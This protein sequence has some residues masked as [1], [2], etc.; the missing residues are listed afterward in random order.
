MGKALRFAIYWL[1]SSLLLTL[2]D[3][4]VSG[5]VIVHQAVLAGLVVAILFMVIDHW[6]NHHR[7]P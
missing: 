7:G 2:V 6:R 4:L 1:G 3:L 5:F